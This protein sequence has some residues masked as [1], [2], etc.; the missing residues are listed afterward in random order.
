MSAE[1]AEWHRRADAL[2]REGRLEE[3]E[4]LIR[5]SVPHIAFAY[6]TAEMHA[7][8]MRHLRAAGDREGAARALADAKRWID[9]YASL[10]TSGGE[11]Y[12]LAAE[13]DRFLASLPDAHGG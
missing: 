6:V 1:R 2:A 3:A 12:A 5:E 11:G 10:A 13:R 7:D 4:R 9:N 8:R